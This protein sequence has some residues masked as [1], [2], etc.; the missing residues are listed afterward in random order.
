MANNDYDLSDPA[1]GQGYYSGTG[2]ATTAEGDGRS[3]LPI[4]APGTSIFGRHRKGCFG[5]TGD[6][7]TRT[8]PSPAAINPHGRAGVYPIGGFPGGADGVYMTANDIPMTGS[9]GE[10]HHNLVGWNPQEM[11]ANAYMY[12]Q[13]QHWINNEQQ[14]A[15]KSGSSHECCTTC[16]TQTSNQRSSKYG[17]PAISIKQ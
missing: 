4:Y 5:T 3:N 1:F 11:D 8:A 13:Q 6:A 10:L 2:P 9:I 15:P 14:N 16:C 7:S 12:Q 17:S